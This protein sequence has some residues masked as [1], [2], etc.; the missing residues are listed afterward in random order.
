MI[1]T[2]LGIPNEEL[3]I[4]EGGYPTNLKWCCN[5]MLEKWLEIDT[6]ASFEKLSAAIHSPAMSRSGTHEDDGKSLISCIVDHF[7]VYKCICFSA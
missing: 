2:L 1:G 3:N 5:R 4:I 7:C 6:T